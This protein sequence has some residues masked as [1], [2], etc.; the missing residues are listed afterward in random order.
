M[1]LLATL[2]IVPM[3]GHRQ[4]I[5][6]GPPKQF[7]QFIGLIFSTVA[8]VL[9]YGVSM[10]NLAEVFMIILAVFACMEACLGFCAGCL[11][12]KYMIKVGIV[13]KETCDRCVEIEG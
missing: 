3:L 6:P 1:G 4:K 9:T 2:V 13:P 12:F 8:I 5:V 7:A 10:A 11:V